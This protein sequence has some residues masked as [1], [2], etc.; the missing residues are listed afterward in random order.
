MNEK[1]KFMID[2]LK[3]PIGTRF[4]YELENGADGF[5]SKIKFIRIVLKNWGKPL[6]W[7][8]E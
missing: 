1:L 4:Y 2:I 6:Y 7:E 8:A 3:K 5:A